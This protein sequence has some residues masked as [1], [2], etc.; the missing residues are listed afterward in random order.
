MRGAKQPRVLSWGYSRFDSQR[1]SIFDG[2]R[3][4]S[5]MQDNR[6]A[7]AAVRASSEQSK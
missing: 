1:T 7:Y 4:D 3:R 5:A 2:S 6:P